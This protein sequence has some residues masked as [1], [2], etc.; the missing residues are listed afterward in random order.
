MPLTH[1]QYASGPDRF[2]ASEAACHAPG[3]SPTG[4]CDMQF[5]PIDRFRGTRT[6]LRVVLFL[7]LLV[8]AYGAAAPVITASAI[9]GG[10]GRS[11]SPGQCFTLDATV[12]QATAGSSMGGSFIL[13]AGFLAGNGDHDSIFNHGFE[14]CT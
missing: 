13:D 9:V 8:S 1:F 6:G 5:K 10:G 14:E 7:C 12:G 3:N 2:A 4:G 11:V